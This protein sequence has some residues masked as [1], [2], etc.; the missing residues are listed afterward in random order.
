VRSNPALKKWF[1]II[2]KRFFKGAC[3]DRVCVRWANDAEEKEA[4]W[5][6][7]Y[8]GWVRWVGT[9]HHDYEIVL[10]KKLNKSRINKFST[11]AHEAI[12][13]CTGLRDEHGAAFEAWRQVISDNGFFKKHALVKNLT[14]F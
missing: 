2:N 14:L 6:A 12:H 11:I 5:E 3:T 7:Q 8:Y 1:R 4:R 9:R 13:C 10:S